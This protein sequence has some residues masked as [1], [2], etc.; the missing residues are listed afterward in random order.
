L[1]RTKPSP[2][3]PEFD[4]NSPEFDENSPEFNENSPEFVDILPF[5]YYSSA[6]DSTS[7]GHHRVRLAKEK[8][9]VQVRRRE[10]TG[11]EI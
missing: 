3:S 8:L 7:Q 4:E 11:G 9:L 1:I 5:D 10:T 6:I 2:E